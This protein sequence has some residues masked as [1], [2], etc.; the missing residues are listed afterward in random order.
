METLLQFYLR[1]E[2]CARFNPY[3]R[4]GGNLIVILPKDRSL[5]SVRSLSLNMW[6]PYYNFIQGKKLV[7]G[8]ILIT[9]QVETLL[10][11]YLRTEACAWFN[12]YHRTVGNLII[13][14]PKDRNLCS[15]RSLSS[16]MWK[17]YYNFTYGHKPV[18]GLIPITE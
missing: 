10:Q 18:L 6:K 5:C 15:V 11:F 3:H 16:N 17:P 13:I 4:I 7:L 14:L 9:K 1:T 2:A 8:S 12:L